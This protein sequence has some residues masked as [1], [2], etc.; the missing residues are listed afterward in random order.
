MDMLSLFESSL[1]KGGKMKSKIFKFNCLAAT[2]V[3]GLGVT[4]I[5]EAAVIIVRHGPP[6]PPP[7]IHCVAYP[8]FAVCYINGYPQK[9]YQFTSVKTCVGHG[10][11]NVQRCY[12]TPYK[13]VC[14]SPDRI[15]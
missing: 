5:G 3:L 9:Y 6:P 1:K 14:Y 12:K 10:I 15:Y 2:I 11:C 4:S 13:A 7:P 8:K